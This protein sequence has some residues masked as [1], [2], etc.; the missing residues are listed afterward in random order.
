M[1]I[2]QKDTVLG[3]CVFSQNVRTRK[4]GEITVFYVVKRAHNRIKT[5]HNRMKKS[6]N[7]MMIFEEFT[8]SIIAF[9]P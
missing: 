1:D 8:V 2:L 9:Y 6:Y 5:E 3:N 4:S 7:R